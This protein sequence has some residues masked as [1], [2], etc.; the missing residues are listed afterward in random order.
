M[1]RRVL[2]LVLVFLFQGIA[3]AHEF[4]M[5]P[6]KFRYTVGEEAKIDFVV[7]ENFNGEPWDLNVHKVEKMELI[8]STGKRDLTSAVKST[9]GNNLTYKMAA[10]GTHLFTLRSNT[11]SIDLEAEKFN[12]YLTED[13]IDNIIQRRKERNETALGV[14]EH[15][16]RFS[17]LLLQSGTTMD[18][19]YKRNVGFPIEIIPETNPYRL[20]SGDYLGCKVL[21]QNKPLAHQL[22][23]VWSI[24]GNRTFVQN[25][26]TEN[27]G[28]IKFPV[29]SVGPWM[30]STVT[31]E[32]SDKEGVDYESMWASLVFGVDRYR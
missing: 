14:K 16:Q 3:I 24:V 27:D 17:K 23:K 4:W 32:P 1:S 26:Y 12:A 10:Q 18:E 6:K 8:T 20:A 11:A 25:M 21:Y 22:V 7:G 2:A 28:T 31:M 19:V 30:V 15:Y 13:G 29:S 9:K 5:R